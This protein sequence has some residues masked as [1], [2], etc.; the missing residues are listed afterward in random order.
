MTA[1]AATRF[2]VTALPQDVARFVREQGRDPTWGHPAL[3][4]QAT[5]LDPVGSA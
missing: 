5:G 4:E 1:I 2:A 3:T